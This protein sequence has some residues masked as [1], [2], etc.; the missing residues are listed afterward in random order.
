MTK[1]VSHAK[2]EVMTKCAQTAPDA[3]QKFLVALPQTGGPPRT[4][5]CRNDVSESILLTSAA[6]HLT[7]KWLRNTNYQKAN[8]HYQKPLWSFYWTHSDLSSSG[9]P[10]YMPGTLLHPCTFRSIEW[11]WQELYLVTRK[12]STHLVSALL[13]RIASIQQWN[14][15]KWNGKRFLKLEIQI[16]VPVYYARQNA[17]WT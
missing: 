3:D 1:L 7:W 8:Y 12:L 9:G 14:D 15:V 11:A 16:E 6:G 5:D 4:S 13:C 10:S 17:T 2:S